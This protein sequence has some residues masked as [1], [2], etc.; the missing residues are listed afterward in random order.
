MEIAID[1][2][3]AGA[4]S[5]DGKAAG[6]QRVQACVPGDIRFIYE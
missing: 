2:D 4:A 1:E 6:H 3:A 5:I